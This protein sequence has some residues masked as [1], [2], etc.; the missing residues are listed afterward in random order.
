M[1]YSNLISFVF[2]LIFSLFE[3][4]TAHAITN[5]SIPDDCK[6][7]EE[8]INMIG[9]DLQK[10]YKNLNIINCCNFRQITCKNLNNQAV[11]TEIKFNNYE[12]LSNQDMGKIISQFAKLPHLTTLEMSDNL[13]VGELPNN[14]SEL[15]KLQKLDLRG[16]CWNDKNANTTLSIK[17]LNKCI[18][19]NRIVKNFTHN[20]LYLLSILAIFMIN[21]IHITD[22][23]IRL[24]EMDRIYKSFLNKVFHHLGIDIR[25]NVWLY[26]IFFLIP[27]L[28]Y[29]IF[30]QGT[31]ISLYY[32]LSMDNLI[33]MKVFKYGYLAAIILQI[34]YKF[35]ASTFTIR[36]R[37]V[38]YVFDLFI[39]IFP[40]AYYIYGVKLINK[41]EELM[42]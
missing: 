2:F 40:I 31:F 12:N 19:S 39:V 27:L 22:V 7:V 3:T 30:H 13:I 42:K 24:V 25:D 8:V 26:M 4:I 28:S 9:N 33:L 5:D 18:I 21:F 23:F 6:V 38:R 32:G 17:E 14:L 41:Y 35:T 1:K 16:N 29:T 15:K 36:E 10:T 37:R 11:V 34:I 20:V